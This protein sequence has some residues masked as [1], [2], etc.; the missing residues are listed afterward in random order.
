MKKILIAMCSLMLLAGCSSSKGTMKEVTSSEVISMI[1][2]EEDFLLVVGTTT[3]SACIAYDEVLKE[4]AKN[5]EGT[6]Y[7][8]Y[9]DKE[10]TTT[11][12]G[13]ET[14]VDFASLQELIGVVEATP[15]NFF[16]IDGSVER[17]EVGMLDYRT[18]KDKVTQYLPLQ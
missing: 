15:T 14:R 18:L 13:V 10:E 1:E 2:N 9:I 16:I 12:D 6:L 8:L 4:Y 5:N 17:T 7:K 11:V 3:C